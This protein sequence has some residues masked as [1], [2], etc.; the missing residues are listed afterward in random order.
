MPEDSDVRVRVTALVERIDQHRSAGRA[1][2][3]NEQ[4]AKLLQ[5]GLEPGKEGHEGCGIKDPSSLQP[6]RSAL[7][8]RDQAIEHAEGARLEFAE[9]GPSRRLDPA[10]AELQLDRCR[11]GEREVDR[12]V[13]SLVLTRGQAPLEVFGVRQ[14]ARQSRIRRAGVGI[15]EA[16]GPHVDQLALEV[17]DDPG[18]GQRRGVPREA[19]RQPWR[20]QV[21][22]PSGVELGTRKS[23]DVPAAAETADVAESRRELS[24]KSGLR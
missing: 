19:D 1:I 4:A 23:L 11:R 5:V 22:Q 3:A 20:Q 18:G 12:D 8:C 21:E 24:S 16:R 7:P 2:A 17:M 14:R 9:D 13:I 15:K 6:I 10:R